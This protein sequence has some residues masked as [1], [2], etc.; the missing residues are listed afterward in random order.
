VEDVME[1]ELVM[2]PLLVVA[3]AITVAAAVYEPR[4]EVVE[5]N[6]GYSVSAEFVVNEPAATVVSVLT[7]FER[8]P[9]FM[10]DVNVS[11]I[12]ERTGNALVVEQEATAKFMMFSK[13]VHLV[14]DVNEDNGLIRFRDRC[15]RSFSRYQGSW[16][17]TDED[18]RS[19]VVYRLDAKPN[20]DVPAFV[21]KRLLK[22]DAA[23]MIER[24][25]TEIAAR[26]TR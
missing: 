24:L 21:L 14:L 1:K 19:V 3:A 8:I 5:G 4:I 13:K 15:G 7:D 23:T 18:S 16:T 12:V 9:R 6:G 11:R 22:R 2:V 10:P 25:Q 20:F 26:A 17:V